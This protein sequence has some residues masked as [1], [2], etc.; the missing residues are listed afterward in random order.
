LEGERYTKISDNIQHE[1]TRS[2]WEKNR[3]ELLRAYH[4]Q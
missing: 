1:N 4:H 3:D 2:G